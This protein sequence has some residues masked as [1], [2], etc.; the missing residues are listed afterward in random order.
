MLFISSNSTN[1]RY[2]YMD[3]WFVWSGIQL[4]QGQG[5]IFRIAGRR[6]RRMK[7]TYEMNKWN[8]CYILIP[9]VD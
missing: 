2:A 8:R 1:E 6:G 7:K 9:V 5:I 4:N 3:S